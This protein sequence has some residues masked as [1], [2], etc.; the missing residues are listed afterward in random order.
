MSEVKK[1]E[2]AQR[3]GKS[4][5]PL[6]NNDDPQAVY[7]YGFALLKRGDHEAALV[8][9]DHVLSLN[10]NPEFWRVGADIG[11]GN[12]LHGMGKRTEA[13]EAFDAALKRIKNYQ[14]IVKHPEYRTL[15]IEAHCGRGQILNQFK[16][17]EQAKKAFELASD[18]SDRLVNNGGTVDT[19]L[20]KQIHWGMGSALHGLAKEAEQAHNKELRQQYNG[21]AKMAYGKAVIVMPESSAAFHCYGAALLKSGQVEG[22]VA[23]LQSAVMLDPKWPL[24]HCDLACAYEYLGER[25]EAIKAFCH[26]L[27]LDP[28]LTKAAQGYERLTGKNY[29]ELSKQ[30]RQREAALAQQLVAAGL[31]GKYKLTPLHKVINDYLSQDLGAIKPL[32]LQ[33]R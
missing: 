2:Q 26:A 22:A 7:R 29:G 9:F 21:E 23:A 1:S 12:A 11:R 25:E 24:A 32:K 31:F 27:T 8:A 15:A 14:D 6:P 30:E 19:A 28:Q 3:R 13:L 17:Y 16:K 20:I 18:I 33:H 5:L 10:P 4:D